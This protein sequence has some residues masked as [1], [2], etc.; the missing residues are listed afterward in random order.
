MITLGVIADTHVPDRARRLHPEVLQVFEKAQ[1]SEILHA[2]DLSSARILDQLAEIAPVRAVRGNR[3]IFVR[4][5][6]LQLRL[7]YEQ[8]TIGMTHGHG[9]WRKYLV[10]K[11]RYL[12]NGP[13]RFSYFENLAVGIFPDTEVVIFGHNH[14]PVNKRRGQQLIFNPGSPTTKPPFLPNSRFTVGLLHIDGKKVRGEIIP[15]T[16]LTL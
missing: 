16:D 13:T 8:V 3:D 11:F 1:V 4:G 15:L 2:G 7:Q 14:A 9:N 10:E 5:L 12:V 6:P